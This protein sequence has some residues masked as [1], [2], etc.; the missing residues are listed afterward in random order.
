MLLR[1]PT[2]KDL[3]SA[4]AGKIG[5]PWTE[6]SKILLDT[7][8][9]GQP[10]PKISIV[11]PSYNQGKFIEECI[12]SVL[13]QG[14][15]NLEYIIIDGGSTDETVEIIKK[16]EPW[17]AHW[18]SEPDR[19][20][21]H[22]INKGLLKSTGRFFN[23]HNS[24]DILTPNSLATMASTII[25]YPQAGYIHGYRILVD[26]K[27]VIQHGN[28]P[29]ESDKVSFLP[30]LTTAISM[31]KSGYQPGCLMD[32]Q[33]AVEVG[34]VDE[35]LHYIMDID[36]LLRIA[37]VRRPVYIPFPAVYLRIHP[38]A[39]STKWNSQR[40]KERIY[41]AGKIFSRSDLPDSIK[42]LKGQGLAAAHQFAWRC[43]GE[44]RM[45][46]VALWH[47]LLDI[48]YSPYNGWRRRFANY[49]LLRFGNRTRSFL[50]KT[51]S[52]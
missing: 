1:S 48:F 31:L 19:G 50:E 36:I 15:P 3:P 39:K 5:W 34:M 25:K 20:Q 14:Y 51:T 40:A 42:K 6:Q 47:L 11:T 38:E 43:Y 7:A 44:A 13:L 27:S 26:Y 33:L 12:R 21:S 32:R 10:W 23:W 41:L 29:I 4:P 17:L 2:L 22:A 28:E 30:E 37:L 18:E 45:Y 9:D 24:D 52:D 16:Y 8:P 49:K 35:S 46:P